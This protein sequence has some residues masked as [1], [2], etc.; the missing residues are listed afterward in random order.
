MD[1]LKTLVSYRSVT[2]DSSSCQQEIANRLESIGFNCE[3]L[4]YS[5]ADLYEGKP[6]NNLWASIGDPP[7]FVFCG[8]T[9]VV[10]P[11]DEKRWTHP[12]FDPTEK[13]GALWG[14]GAVDMKGS[15]AA[16]IIAVRDYLADFGVAG[17]Q[18]DKH[19]A[20]LVKSAKPSSG[21]A[22]LI[23]GDEEGEAVDGVERVLKELAKRKVDIAQ[24]LLG[25][26]TCAERFGDTIKN[27]RRGS[28]RLEA[29]FRGAQRHAAYI[30][31][32]DNLLHR[33]IFI[34]NALLAENWDKD[35]Q[36]PPPGTAFNVVNLKAPSAAENVTAQRI[37]LLC[38]WRYAPP[39]DP[40]L[41]KLKDKVENTIRDG[42]FSIVKDI[43]EA[44]DQ[45]FISRVDWHKGAKPYF[46]S[47]AALV[48][49]MRQAI[50]DILGIQPEVATSGGSIGWS[51]L[52][53][54]WRDRRG[55]RY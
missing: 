6:V 12:P 7:Y 49:N 10:P 3:L 22:F 2:P 34:T 17:L 18:G 8:H 47:Q 25:E 41:D 26:P 27:G 21:I 1:L 51:L 39:L 20:R 50:Y 52:S 32:R 5:T 33:I 42:G 28:L 54:L 24:C 40:L 31:R 15:V 38:N 55:Y 36:A 23:T 11:G 30:S 35:I 14:R 19:G 13:N 9:D 45:E 37:K 4:T 46:S 53:G 16:M 48:K 43:T 29:E 44:E